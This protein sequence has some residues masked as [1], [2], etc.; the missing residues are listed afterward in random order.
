MKLSVMKPSSPSPVPSSPA[1]HV[2]DAA[3]RAMEEASGFTELAA[4]MTGVDRSRLVADASILAE[5]AP[6]GMFSA[7]AKGAVLH[8]NAQWVEMLGASAVS[9]LTGFQWADAIHP[10]DL[11]ALGSGWQEA[12]RAGQPYAGIFRT[13]E[14]ATRPVRWIKFRAR[15]VGPDLAPIAFVGTAVD[16]TA[17]VRLE[18]ELQHRNRQLARALEASGLALWEIDLRSGAVHL[19]PGWTRML[20]VA[21]GVEDINTQDAMRYFP[22]E[23]V[24]R[25]MEGRRKLL[26]GEIPHLSL[27]HRMRAEDGS[28]VWVLTQAE[29]S[30]RGPDGRALYVV[31]TCKDITERKRTYAE[32]HRALE[33][34]D[35]ASQ[36]KSDFLATM[37]H[38]I[39]TPLNGVIGLTQLLAAADLPPMEKDSVGMIDSCAKSLLSLVDNILDFSKIEAGRLTL[40]LVPTDLPQ[41]VNEVADVFLVRAGEKGIRFDLRQEPGLPR[42]ISAD[43]GRL[44]QILLN[45][46]GNALKFTTEGGFSLNVFVKAD[47]QPPQ[48][49]FQVFDTGMGI[50]E[51]DQ[52]RLFTRFSQVDASASRRHDGSG[53]GLAISRQ[54]AQLMGGDV[55]LVSRLGH[56][57][58][59]TVTI[60]LQVARAPAQVERPAAHAVREN[61]RILL[62]EDNEVNQL[63]AQRLL[64]KLGY[65]NVTVAF[66]GR[67]AVEACR[68]GRYDLV[69]MDCQMPVMDGLEASRVLREDGMQAPIIAFTASA[70]SGDRDRCLAAGM[71]DYLTKPV[72]MAVLADKLQRWLGDAPVV[73]PE[74]APPVEAA[75]ALPAFDS[76][77]IEERF[78]GDLEL[79]QQ[80]RE[81]FLRQTREGLQ[82]SIGISDGLELKR[83]AHRIRG[84][85]AT[86]GAMQLAAVCGRLEDEAEGLQPAQMQAGVQ[87]AIARLDAFVA[88][89]QVAVQ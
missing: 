14:T 80:A 21:G 52:A 88:E 69:L 65:P 46:L 5:L 49:C 62:A 32:L 18:Q 86:L 25:V 48:L 30:E 3:V 13:R 59:F 87:E 74:S 33:A 37:S 44:R 31:G 16:V 71:N 77:A 50:S 17:T 51:A 39:R 56:G 67:E 22:R 41:L 4:T 66:T 54:L 84:S 85:A 89:S 19:S 15:M 10:Q 35:A 26:K 45:L 63:V 57:S 40:E 24:P 2:Q 42:W 61:V 36:A 27:E 7:D 81:I 8:G 73:A 11:D 47:A 83:L 75:P 28:L 38:E 9:E 6:V 20:K 43:P 34:A 12:V 60:P 68:T 29:V 55:T 78:Y 53:L 1:R 70:T 79:F 82:K 58:T 76:S 64:A 72:E 23:E